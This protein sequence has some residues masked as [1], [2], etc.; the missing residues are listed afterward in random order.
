MSGI[1][2]RTNNPSAWGNGQGSDLAAAQIDM[3]FWILYS[4]ILA[5]QDHALTT[6]NQIDYFSVV[7]DQMFVTMMNHQVFG[8][9][10]LPVA[11]WTFRGQWE[12]ATSYAPM[13]VVTEN[14]SVY[15]VLFAH[16]SAATFD[17]G[18]NDGDG[19]DFYGLMI[20]GSTGSGLPDGGTIGQ[21]LQVLDNGSPTGA[22]ITQWTNLPRLIGVFIPGAVALENQLLFQFVCVE[23]MTFPIGLTGSEAYALFPPTRDQIYDFYKNGA[24]IG[25]VEFTPSPETAI[26]T[27]SEAVTCLAGDRITMYGPAS[28]GPDPHMQ[29]ISI[30][31]VAT[32]P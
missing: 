20:T 1:V 32:L 6:E 4:S 8:P 16:I 26:F 27:F 11:S 17:A 13:D 21:V 15:L 19:H 22:P 3:N 24:F 5:L 23:E 25:S 7:G 9:F 14:N 31:L 28:P 29:D 2:Y 10:T 30:T 12:P 18:A